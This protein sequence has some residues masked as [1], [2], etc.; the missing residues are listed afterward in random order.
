MGGPQATGPNEVMQYA[1]EQGL[2]L[3]DDSILVQPGENAYFHAGWAQLFWP[4][5]PVILESEHYGG[6]KARGCWQDG[7]LYLKA[8]EDY[9]ASYASIHWWPHEFL[10]ENRELVRKINLR[11]GYRLQLLEAKWPNTVRLGDP[12]KLASGWRNVGVAPCLPNGYPTWTL[13]DSQGGITAVLVDEGF[14]VRDLPVGPPGKAESRSRESSFRLPFQLRPGRHDVFI[15]IGNRTGTPKIAL[16]LP[17]DDGHQRYRLGVVQVVGA[18]SVRAGLLERRGAGYYLPLNWTIRTP[19]PDD[20]RPFCHFDLD[21]RIC[22]QGFPESEDLIPSLRKP[23]TVKFGCIF[24]APADTGQKEF[25]VH[26]GL[27]SPEL[28]GKGDNAERMLA[29]EGAQDRRVDVGRLTVSRDG[30]VVLAPLPPQK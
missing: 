19:L 8:I 10:E 11:L 6:S 17:G 24:T 12:L 23:G 27:W 3:R 25:S 5:T 30:S 1:V 22:F 7:R 9:H 28:Q 14:D 2:T 21:E 15:S 16:P 18:Y 26:V 13:K 29:E 4:K 20:V